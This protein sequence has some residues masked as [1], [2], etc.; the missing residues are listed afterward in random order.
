M[1]VDGARVD[2]GL[3]EETLE[4]LVDRPREVGRRHFQKELGKDLGKI[5]E[6][7]DF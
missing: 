2:V 3:E 6:W 1:L 4:A 5:V 7:S